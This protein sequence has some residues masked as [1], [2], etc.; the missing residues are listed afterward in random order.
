MSPR[1]ARLEL[2]GYKSFAAKSKFVFGDGVTCVV[3]PNGSGKSNIADG[4]RW[5][6]G[7]QSYTSL[8]GRKT[9]DMIF[10]G[11][12]N[13][14]R[15]SMAAVTVV[16][17][18]ADG[19]L[20]ID[21]SEVSITRRAYRDGQNEYLLNGQRMRLRDINELL[22]SVGLAKRTYTVIGQGLVDSALSLRAEERRSLFEEAAGIG[23]YRQKREETVRR[24]EQAKRN[25]ERIQ[26][27]VA[28]IG[29]RLRS[30]QR[31]AKKAEQHGQ[32][33]TDLRALLRIW[34]G[35]HWHI[36]QEEL[37]K[38][39][40]YS[41]EQT[42]ELKALQADQGQAVAA[43]TDLRAKLASHRTRRTE[44][45]DDM[46]CLQSEY[47][48]LQREAA[49][50]KERVRN[51]TERG[52]AQDAEIE[53]AN[54][55]VTEAGDKAETASTDVN[56][57]D[58]E[59][60]VIA[61][62]VEELEIRQG[63]LEDERTTLTEL[64]REAQAQTASIGQQITAQH[65]RREAAA[66]ERT[67]LDAERT[68]LQ[69][70]IS[71][72]EAAVAETHS[73]AAE[74]EAA[75]DRARQSR[76]ENDTQLAANANALT[77]VDSALAKNNAA[78]S[79]ATTEL[80]RLRARLEVLQQEHSA[81][82]GAASG[83]R[84]LESA[85]AAGQFP[86]AANAI[87]DVLEIDT[88]YE[89]AIAAALGQSLHALIVSDYSSVEAARELLAGRGRAL[90]AH[91][92]SNRTFERPQ[93]LSPHADMIGFAA[94]VV[95]F[96]AEYGS[97]VEA[98]LGPV[99]ICRTHA[100]A[101]NVASA[102]PPGSLAVTLDGE[103]HH[104]DGRIVV[105]ASD[106]SRALDLA[107]EL[108]LL[109]E[110]IAKSKNVQQET[111]SVHANLERKRNTLQAE[112]TRFMAARQTTQEIERA[113]STE[114]DSARLTHERAIAAHELIQ[115][116][117]KTIAE[118][119]RNLVQE[120]VKMGEQLNELTQTHATTHQQ[121]QTLIGR[122]AELMTPELG[123]EIATRR[124]ALAVA[125]QALQNSRAR[126][127]EVRADLETEQSALAE[128]M[129]RIE[130]RKQE[131]LNLHARIET[132]EVQADELAHR[133]RANQDELGPSDSQMRLL[134]NELTRTE[135]EES[136]IRQTLHNLEKRHLD[137]RL[138]F[139]SKRNQLDALRRRIEDD[140]GL[141]DLAFGD[142]LTGHNPL[143]L[144]G[145]VVHLDPVDL[146]PDDIE[147]EIN[148]YRAQMRRMGSINPDAVREHE[149]V[150]ER[151]EHLSTQITDLDSAVEQMREVIAEL[152]VLMEH[153]FRKT[154]NEVARE[155]RK[156]FTQLFG[157]GQ[158]QLHLTNPDDLTTTGIDIL[159][160]LPGKRE[161]GLGLLS[162]GERS[163]TAS[164]LIFA[165]LRV[166]P[167]P[168]AL[169]DEV[170]AMLD[171]AN[172]GR[173][174]DLLRDLSNQTQFIIITHNS[175]TVEVADTVYGISMGP[176]GASQIMSLKLDGDQVAKPVADS[177]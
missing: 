140:F 53:E 153:E 88:Q 127:H 65:A 18:N 111:K 15:A 60:P 11:T 66:A 43:L 5:V 101:R 94:D 154:F 173:F 95:E 42:V 17:D 145:Q 174:R 36:E 112:T 56:R 163:L 166:S 170:D 8:R 118:L 92:S 38:A 165:L 119:L 107:R 150:Q 35:Y 91:L 62:Q 76:S 30:L 4:L 126:L 135:S 117:I 143:P 93:F 31:Q 139:E 52:T 142:G 80:E 141:V 46:A 81:L 132:I 86:G 19:W 61:R 130:N 13:R 121:A 123:D 16:F 90:L 167:T 115:A 82:E 58:Q 96:S 64:I 169:L 44:R 152:D 83:R 109:P 129:A 175:H 125:E 131:A 33:R 49:V 160:Q 144:E 12:E 78:L 28:E 6:L 24:L 34:Y 26:D 106:D 138:Q 37:T 68:N 108:D 1:L 10:S 113:A 25:L 171:E 55:K 45:R 75:A 158:A 71:A 157:G 133:I 72:A 103:V 97:V 63:M 100:G 3:G 14:A 136:R 74:K 177:A 77:E 148:R 47:E 110:Q 89:T 114:R 2:Q 73:E 40:I 32:I 87:V 120:D 7:E 137:A 22:A 122:R 85:A 149:E 23:A 155:F 156:T 146:L 59:R 161:Q 29:P 84:L 151:Y 147:Q 98:L 124:T 79:A 128:R 105:G 39:S 21:F 172:V 134:E 176:D 41:E 54:R 99:V 159:T 9:E 70:G 50:A 168:F 104:A 69:G 162:G 164:A 102:L 116:Q 57:L 48:A 51:L 20:P 27:I 67:R